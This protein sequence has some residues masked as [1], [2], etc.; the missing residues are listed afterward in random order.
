MKTYEI[1]E[2]I[3]FILT[4][5][6]LIIDNIAQKADN[7]KL[8]NIA[9]ITE[10]MKVLCQEAES[11][12]KKPNEKKDYALKGVEYLCEKFK[13]DYDKDF[14]SKAIDSFIWFTKKI[15]YKNKKE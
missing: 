8:K 7:K 12:S 13:V 5:T 4:I 6:G 9:K 2:L 10:E 14:W 3:V 15:N 11:I 1:L